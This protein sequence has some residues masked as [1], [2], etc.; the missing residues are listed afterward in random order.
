MLRKFGLALIF[1]SVTLIT[2]ACNANSEAVSVLQTENTALRATLASYD[3]LGPTAT[4]RAADLAQKMATTQA[5]LATARGEVKRLTAQLNSGGAPLNSQPIT[6]PPANN[7][8]SSFSSVAAQNNNT[9]QPLP[10]ATNAQADNS[11]QDPNGFG[12][13]SVVTSRGKDNSGCAVNPTST[14]SA[15]DNA[16]YVVAEVRNYKR[17]TKFLAHWEGPNFT[18]D[19]NWTASSGGAK[20]CVH[21]WVEPQTLGM[22]AGTYT[23]TLSANGSNSQ[24]VTFTLQGG[25][26]M[27]AEATEA[28]SQK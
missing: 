24:A 17:G 8:G 13:N 25:A 2:A 18:R 5:E 7:D 10:A 21:F 26:V 15:I 3:G 19:N 4:A 22:Q 14:F 1:I 9:G 12:F 16:V 6:A 23:V 20:I 11:Q 27:E 28:A